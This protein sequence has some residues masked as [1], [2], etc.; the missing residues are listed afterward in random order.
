MRAVG[1]IFGV[2]PQQVK[3]GIRENLQKI[4]TRPNA[5]S[6]LRG[7]I[8]RYCL[9]N[10]KLSVSQFILHTARELVEVVD[11]TAYILEMQDAEAGG[12][13]WTQTP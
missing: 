9:H 11:N 4:C 8:R 6:D 2:S 12:E 5:P 13:R 1:H 10:G 3:N 7:S